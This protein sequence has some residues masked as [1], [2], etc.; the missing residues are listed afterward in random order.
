MMF[1]IQIFQMDM[2]SL[3]MELNDCGGQISSR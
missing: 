3:A 2:I 1:I